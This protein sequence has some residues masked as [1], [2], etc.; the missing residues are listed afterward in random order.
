[1]LFKL[2]CIYKEESVFNF[3]NFSLNPSSRILFPDKDL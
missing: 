3:L 2:L 1:M